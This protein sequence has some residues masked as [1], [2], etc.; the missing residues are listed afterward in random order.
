M[1]QSILQEYS[2]NANEVPNIIPKLFQV[3]DIHYKSGYRYTYCQLIPPIV[4]IIKIR[5]SQASH[6]KLMVNYALY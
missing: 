6:M 5:I 4:T 2:G 1:L 3:H